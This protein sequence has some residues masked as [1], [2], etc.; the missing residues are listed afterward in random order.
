M[1]IHFSRNRWQLVRVFRMQWWR[2]L[3]RLPQVVQMHVCACKFSACS[4]VCGTFLSYTDQPCLALLD[5]AVS[6]R[7]RFP[8]PESSHGRA[9]ARARLAFTS[10]LRVPPVLNSSR[11]FSRP[12]PKIEINFTQCVRVAASLPKYRDATSHPEFFPFLSCS[13]SFPA[14]RLSRSLLLARARAL[15]CSSR[16]PCEVARLM[17]TQSIYT[18][19]F[20]LILKLFKADNSPRWSSYSRPGFFLFFSLFFFRIIVH[21]RACNSI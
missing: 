7:L 3:E 2:N 6:D 16:P 8:D 1:K 20:S 5:P 18:Y 21:T 11:A 15:A 10:E 4:D 12:P 9:R 19:L 14:S 17:H 13:C